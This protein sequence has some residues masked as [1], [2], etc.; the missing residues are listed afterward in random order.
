MANISPLSMRRQILL[1]L[2]DSYEGKSMNEFLK[3]FNA[4]LGAITHTLSEMYNHYDPG[5]GVIYINGDYN[6]LGV[7]FAEIERFGKV[8]HFNNSGKSDSNINFLSEGK[9]DL[10]NCPFM[11]RITNKGRVELEK[12]KTEESI[13]KVNDSVIRTNRIT[14]FLASL[15]AVCSIIAL[16]NNGNDKSVSQ[17]IRSLN[18]SL[19]EQGTILR[20]LRQDQGGGIYPTNQSTDTSK[21]E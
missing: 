8:L 11:A 20:N 17:E 10:D 19:K 7:D 16:L 12:F 21:T 15:A 18:K 3:K 4:P 9:G 1:Y 2:E 6:F 14:I 13:R 5:S